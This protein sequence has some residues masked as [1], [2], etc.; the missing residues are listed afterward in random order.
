MSCEVLVPMRMWL[1]PG[2]TVVDSGVSHSFVSTAVAF[3]SAFVNLACQASTSATKPC[4]GNEWL[5]RARGLVL[6]EL[7]VYPGTNPDTG[8]RRYRTATVVGNRS[9]IGSRPKLH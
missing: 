4:A 8:K 3:R 2:S 9:D 7:R 1:P 6:R 5:I